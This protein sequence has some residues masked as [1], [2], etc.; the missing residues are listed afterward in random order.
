MIT[1]EQLNGL[2]LKTVDIK[3]KQYIMVNERVKAFRQICPDGQI[4]TDII[5]LDDEAVVIKATITVDGK[6]LSTGYAR[7]EK[8]A[9]YINKSSY[10]ENCETSA[11]GRALAFLGIGI[12]DSMA[13]AD[14]VA[15][16]IMQQNDKP[17][18]K[19]KASALSKLC[20]EKGVAEE[21]LLARYGASKLE[22]LTE[23]Q[24][25]KAVAALSKS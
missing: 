9:S 17:I 24:H 18:G 14:E 21:K 8:N 5:T 6:V 4:T 3:G 15:N 16:A 2:R 22:D 19:I 20:E 25:A 7:E 11:V 23:T 1:A 12:D 13:S 10:V